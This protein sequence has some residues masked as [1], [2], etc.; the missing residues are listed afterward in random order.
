MSVDVYLVAIEKSQQLGFFEEL[1]DPRIWFGDPT[2]LYQFD[3]L[4]GLHNAVIDG[5][6]TERLV[7]WPRDP[8]E[9]RFNDGAAADVRRFLENNLGKTLHLS[10]RFPES[11]HVSRIRVT[12]IGNERV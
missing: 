8:A 9:R 6:T 3:D 4:V 10:L 2:Y 11:I 7:A 5:I 1:Q 12:T